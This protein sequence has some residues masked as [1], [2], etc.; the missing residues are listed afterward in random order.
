MYCIIL[1]EKNVI[2]QLMSGS[3][4]AGQFLCLF[5]GQVLF[6]QF[7]SVHLVKNSKST[8]QILVQ[9]CF[10]TKNLRI[11]KENEGT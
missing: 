7:I 10:G 3:P 1:Q 4:A 8:K 11:Y 9:I 5:A 6:L 2:L